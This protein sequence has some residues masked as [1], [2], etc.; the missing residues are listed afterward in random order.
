MARCLMFQKGMPKVFWV[1]A[2]NTAN[3]ILNMAYTRVLS[4]KTAY[5]MW[6]KHKPSVHV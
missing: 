1:E 2:I 3:Y 4:N 5:E 6:Y